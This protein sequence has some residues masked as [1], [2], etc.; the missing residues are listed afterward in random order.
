M[1]ENV[2]VSLSTDRF[3][4]VATDILDLPGSVHI[5]RASTRKI[6]D[7]FSL[8]IPAFEPALADDRETQKDPVVS[9]GLTR[10]SQ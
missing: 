1:I 4:Y 3:I 5:L 9:L 2:E 7:S 10:D 8:S 6:N